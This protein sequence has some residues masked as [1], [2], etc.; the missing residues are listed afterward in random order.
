MCMVLFI[1]VTIFYLVKSNNNWKCD[2][3]LPRNLAFYSLLIP[4]RLTFHLFYHRLLG[5]SL[6]RPFNTVGALSGLCVGSP[7]MLLDARDNEESLL[8]ISRYTCSCHWS[9]QLQG[10]L[11]LLRRSSKTIN[12][13]ISTSSVEDLL[14]V[15]L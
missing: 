4:G 1:L 3:A 6:I 2:Y 8:C 7:Q 9:S 14:M 15:L 12:R 10:Q 5:L 11:Y 13:S